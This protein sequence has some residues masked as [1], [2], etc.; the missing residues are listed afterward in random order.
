MTGTPPP[1]HTQSI[2]SLAVFET[3]RRLAVSLL[4]VNDYVWRFPLVS[5]DFQS[6]FMSN[7]LKQIQV[8]AL[9]IAKWKKILSR[10]GGII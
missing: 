6:T 9:E 3:E 10:N 4:L 7:D 2:E 8:W 5:E 1:P